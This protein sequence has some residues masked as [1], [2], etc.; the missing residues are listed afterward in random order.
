MPSICPLKR[1]LSRSRAPTA[2]SWNLMLELP[3]LTTR[4]VSVMAQART[5]CFRPVVVRVA[6]SPRRRRHARPDVVGPRGQDDR[7]ARAEHDAGGI[8]VGEERQVLGQHVAGFEVGHDQDLRL[9]GDRRIDAL[10]ARGFGADRV[11]EGERPIEDAARDLAAISHLAERRRLDRR[12]NFGL[13]VSTAD[14]IATF[15]VPSPARIE[16]MAFWTMSRFALRS[17]KMFTAASV[18]NSVSG[19]RARP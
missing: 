15:G 12:R 19:G 13:T 16:S 2:N 9:S 5:G 10:D 11:V 7:H 4:M 14:K 3:A 6:A 1:R 18:M 17:G 8:G